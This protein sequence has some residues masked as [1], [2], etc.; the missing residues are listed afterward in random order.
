[1]NLLLTDTQLLSHRVRVHKMCGC[2]DCNM[3]F[4]FVNLLSH[5]L[6][7]TIHLLIS[8]QMKSPYNLCLAVD[9]KQNVDN[10]FIVNVKHFIFN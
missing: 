8:E 10:L 3:T 1:M 6:S 7:G 4:L 5:A 9:D 2:T